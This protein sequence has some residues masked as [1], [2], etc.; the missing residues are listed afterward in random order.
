MKSILEIFSP[1]FSDLLSFQIQLYNKA[2][3]FYLYLP[4]EE[5]KS[6]RNSEAVMTQEIIKHYI[7]CFIAEQ[8][9]A[10]PRF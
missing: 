4:V 5:I 8:Y 2:H 9:T 10:T 1:P 3:P 7:F 6:C